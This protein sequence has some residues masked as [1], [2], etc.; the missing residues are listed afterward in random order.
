MPFIAEEG[1]QICVL[2]G[3]D[4]IPI[5]RALEGRAGRT[6]KLLRYVVAGECLVSS[7][8]NG[9]AMELPGVLS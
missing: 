9:E 2:D 5:C 1:D 4:G 6:R 7:L 3:I 8:L